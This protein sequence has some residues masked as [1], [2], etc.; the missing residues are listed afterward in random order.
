VDGVAQ[1]KPEPPVRISRDLFTAVKLS[2]TK[3]Y[4]IAQ[5]AGI[6]AVTLSR[7]LHGAQRLRPGD[8]RVLAVAREVGVPASRAFA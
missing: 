1:R 8:P 6:D 7:I 3:S 5:R 4:V 2:P